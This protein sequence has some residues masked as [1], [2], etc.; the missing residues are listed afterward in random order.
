MICWEARSSKNSKLDARLGS[1]SKKWSTSLYM[2]DIKADI[3]QVVNVEWTKQN[4]V[5]LRNEVTSFRWPYPHSNA[6]MY[7]RDV[8]KKWKHFLKQAKTSPFICLELYIDYD[9]WK[10]DRDLIES[11]GSVPDT[12]S[13]S[14]STRKR[15]RAESSRDLGGEKQKQSRSSSNPAGGDSGAAT[16]RFIVS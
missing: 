3:V 10:Q 16:K 12:P 4:L 5:P 1:A 14:V 15:S 2:E 8:P 13:S 6:P 11:M 9:A 7:L